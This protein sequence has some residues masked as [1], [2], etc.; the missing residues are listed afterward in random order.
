MKYSISLED[1]TA[2]VECFQPKEL[3]YTQSERGFWSFK[4]CMHTPTD[5]DSIKKIALSTFMLCFIL[6]SYSEVL[7]YY[8][9]LSFQPQ[10]RQS[11]YVLYV[12]G[13]CV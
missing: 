8:F 9:V 2:V 7:V 5:I 12:W 6:S 1:G 10:P 13:M 11:S 3:E 4:T